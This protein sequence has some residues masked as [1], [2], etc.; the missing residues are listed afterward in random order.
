LK[1]KAPIWKR[2][3]FRPESHRHAT[4]SEAATV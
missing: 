4:R 1:K 2:P 3:R